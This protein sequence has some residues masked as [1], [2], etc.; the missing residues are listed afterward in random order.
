M[1]DRRIFVP[2]ASRLFSDEVATLQGM[3]GA[4][5]NVKDPHRLQSV[6][7]VGL[8][9]AAVCGN[10]DFVKMTSY[11]T[12]CSLAV[13][14]EVSPDQLVLTRIDPTEVYP[15]KNVYRPFLPWDSHSHLCAIPPIFAGG[16]CRVSLESNG[17]TL[18]FPMV[19]PRDVAQDALQK[20]LL[21]AVYTRLAVSDGTIDLAEVNLYTGSVRHLGVEYAIDPEVGDGRSATLAALDNLALYACILVSLLPLACLRLTESLIRHDEHELLQLFRRLVPD[22]LQALARGDVLD[23]RDDM[24]KVNAF[25]TYVQAMATVFN[26][27]H[28]LRVVTYE[29]DTLTASCWCAYN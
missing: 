4:V 29:S 13:L 16:N 11:L 21:K 26:L 7:T 15:L 14:E 8:G 6:Q 27:G 3:V 22:E 1:V 25:F 17:C 12:S 18:I 10:I 23:V 9:P 2:L 24:V 20:L 28:V 19:L 5:I